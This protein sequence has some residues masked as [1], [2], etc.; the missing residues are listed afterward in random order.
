MK[1][2]KKKHFFIKKFVY[3]KKKQYLCAIFR[4]DMRIIP[5]F[6]K[7]IN[8]YYNVKNLSNYRQESHGRMQRFALEASH[9]AQL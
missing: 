4:V 5:E 3:F 9:E 1:Y 6:E 7:N 2:A 8:I